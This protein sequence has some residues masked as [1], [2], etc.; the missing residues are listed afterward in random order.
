M[1]FTLPVQRPW[2]WGST[3]KA[4]S[5]GPCRWG[6]S[7]RF[8]CAGLCIARRCL[9]A[10]SACAGFAVARRDEAVLTAFFALW[11]S[12]GA[13][14]AVGGRRFRWL[15]TIDVA[16]L[17]EAESGFGDVLEPSPVKLTLPLKRTL[18][19]CDIAVVTSLDLTLCMCLQ[20]LLLSFALGATCER[21]F[22]GKRI[23]R[24]GTLLG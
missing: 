7:A 21:R 15:I 19:T 20:T 11:E 5:F 3:S 6:G 2:P 1:V 12:L 18:F 13:G 24:V 14:D 4:W 9:Q 16:P 17:F 22:I 10:L 23:A 8:T